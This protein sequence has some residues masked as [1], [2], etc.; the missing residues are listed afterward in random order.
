LKIRSDIQD[1]YKET[2]IHVCKDRADE[3][4]RR[5]LGE[6]HTLFDETL[7][8]MDDVGNRCSFRPT[9][10]LSFYAEGQKVYA[11][12]ADK[13]Y[14]VTEKL[15]ELEAKLGNHGFVRISKSEI[16]NFRQI[17]N[18]DLSLTGTIRVTMK[19]GY[20]TYASRRNVAKIK[21]MLRKE[22]NA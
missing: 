18:L 10:I 7:A 5:L 20:E 15:Y 22:K 21:E 11:L 6:L 13:R 19:N 12:G 8:G 4:V 16:V 14:S 1:K 9:E 17:R 2:E 3:E